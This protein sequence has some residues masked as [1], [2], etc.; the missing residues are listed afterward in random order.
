MLLTNRQFSSLHIAFKNSSSY[1]IKLSKTQLHKIVQWVGFLGRLLGPLLKTGSPLMK[2]V[3]KPLAKN[4]LI[5]PGSTPPMSATNSAVQKKFFGS[6]WYSSINIF[7]W[8]LEWHHEN[9]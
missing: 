5:L 7:K 3:L 1:N 4:V 2:N 8:T 9:N 6:I